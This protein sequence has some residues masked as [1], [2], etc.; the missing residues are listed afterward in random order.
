MLVIINYGVIR[1]VI[2][3]WTDIDRNEHYCVTK[4]TKIP[5]L[6]LHEKEGTLEIMNNKAV[7]RSASFIIVSL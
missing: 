3:L 7:E 4:V 5:V 2:H 6:F 1:N